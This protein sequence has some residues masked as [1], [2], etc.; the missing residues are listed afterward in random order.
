MSRKDEIAH[1]V[2]RYAKAWLAG[3]AAQII[4]CYGDGFTLHYGGSNAL[5]GDHVGKAAALG[6]LAE[7]SRRTSRRLVRI[8]DVLA[9][10]ERGVVVAREALG[11]DDARVEVERVLVYRVEAGVFAECW[12]HDQDQALIDR[13]VG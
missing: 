4:A 7:F 8:V 2:E 1:A 10:D 9:G 11:P 3:D 13:L 5:S 6:C 12:V